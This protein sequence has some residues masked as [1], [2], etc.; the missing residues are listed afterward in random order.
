MSVW[1]HHHSVC[2]CVCGVCVCS[3]RSVRCS[4]GL[5]HMLSEDVLSVLA[6]G[7]NEPLLQ[8][9]VSGGLQCVCGCSLSCVC[10][11]PAGCRVADCVWINNKHLL[12]LTSALYLYDFTD[13]VYTTQ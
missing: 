11:M 2:V 10:V 9:T 3:L 4:D 7:A 13:P 12:V 6:L 1:V 5:L 8:L